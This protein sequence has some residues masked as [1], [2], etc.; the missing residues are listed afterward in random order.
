MSSFLFTA[1]NRDGKS[2]T[3]RVEAENLAQAKY[4]LEIQ[5]YSEISFY[6]S[7]LSEDTWNLFDEKN[8]KSKQEFLQRQVE[9]QYN[10]SYWQH[11]FFCLKLT[12]ILWIPLTV[13][14]ALSWSFFSFLSLGLFFAV[15][16]YLSLPVI[17]YDKLL[18][19]HF[20]AQN[21]KVRFWV[22]ISKLFNN[23]SFLKIPPADLDSRLSCADAREG[24]LKLALSRMEKYQNVEK[25]PRRL[26]NIYLGSIYGNA[27]KYDEL[28]KLQENALQEGNISSEEMIDY[29][30]NLARWQKKT[31]F[32]REILDKALDSEMT[33]MMQLFVPFCKGLIE[34]EDG[35]FPQAEFYLQLASKQIEPFKKNGYLVGLRS[36]IK[37]FLSIVLGTRGE[38]AEAAKLFYE[39]KPYLLAHKETDLLRRCEG[40][41]N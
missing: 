6:E 11:V 39:A 24:N 23:I 13:W 19:A 37:A 18:M 3:E 33:A 41:I 36:E 25:V 8:K 5:G 38:K 31:N 9:I 27:K 28:L 1:V 30:M 10:T 26:L 4:K 35:N 17:F 34:I 40:A 32:A 14:V 29:A 7:D 20:R 12:A 16:I 21:F 2:V 15:F 22:K